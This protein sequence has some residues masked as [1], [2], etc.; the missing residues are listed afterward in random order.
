ML[1]D[2]NFRGFA[3]ELVWVILLVTPVP[4]AKQKQN[5]LIHDIR[6]LLE[7]KII[8]LTR[9]LYQVAQLEPISM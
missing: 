4:R 1:S 6:I 3:V 8:I 9:F 2:T 7:C 5:T